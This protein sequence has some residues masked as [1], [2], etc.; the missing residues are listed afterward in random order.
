MHQYN[1]DKYNKVLDRYFELIKENKPELKKLDISQ[2]GLSDLDVYVLSS[3]LRTYNQYICE[4]DL[5]IN[6]ISDKSVEYLTT[7]VNVTILVLHDNNVSENGAKHLFACEHLKFVDLERNNLHAH[8]TAEL[9]AVLKA[10]TNPIVVNVKRNILGEEN[11]DRL[12]SS[13]SRKKI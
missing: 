9:E 3:V 2:A 7:L 13:G 5:S 4:L 12:T 11:E 8:R 10:R 1:M 6:N